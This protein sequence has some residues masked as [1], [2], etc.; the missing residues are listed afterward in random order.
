MVT[1]IF[2]RGLFGY[3]WVTLLI[4]SME[5]EL[6]VLIMMTFV[7]AMPNEHDNLLTNSAFICATCEFTGSIKW[8]NQS[9]T[10]HAFNSSDNDPS[11]IFFCSSAQSY[12]YS[13][14]AID[15]CIFKY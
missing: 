3:L 13:N 5:H 12:Q 4:L 10:F 2:L 14:V 8:R 11:Q 6:L 1:I 7:H 15:L 9:P